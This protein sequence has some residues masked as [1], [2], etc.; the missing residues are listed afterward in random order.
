MLAIASLAVAC[1][2]HSASTEPKPT[3][4]AD[5]KPPAQPEKGAKPVEPP[6]IGDA[7]VRAGAR[8]FFAPTGDAGF[9]LPT[10]AK[11][12]GMAVHVVGE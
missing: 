3:V 9:E 10:L 7:V 5:A 1:A 11:A 2:D 8:L 4:A 6:I 12:R